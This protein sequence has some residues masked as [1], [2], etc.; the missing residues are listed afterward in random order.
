MTPSLEIGNGNW[1]VQ[2]DSLLGYKTINGKYYPREMSVTRA[3]TATRVNAAGL[4]ELVPYNLLQYSEDFSNVIWVKTQSTIS[5]NSTTSPS[6]LVNADTL[7][8]DGVTAQ[9]FVYQLL[10]VTSGVSY[11]MSTYA[12]KNTNN[13]VQIAGGSVL[14]GANAWANFDLNSGV[15]GSV[16]SAATATIT[17][18][19]NGWYRCTM[20][21]PAIATISGLSALYVLISSATSLRAETNSLSTSVFLWGAQLVEGTQ[22]LNYL[23]TTDRL[24]IAR[25]DYSLGQ[26]NLL[27]EPQRTNAIRNST[28][29]GAVVGSPGTLPTNWT[30]SLIGLTREI[31][32][33]GVENGLTYIDVRFSGVSTGNSSQRILF[34]NTTQISATPS[35]NWSLSAYIK[36]V[37][38]PLPPVSAQFL[39]FDLNSSG[40]FIGAGFQDISI[41]NTLNRFSYSRTTGTDPLIARLQPILGFTTLAGQSYDFTF[42]IAAPQ[43]EAGAFPT[44]FIPTISTSVTRNADVISRSNIFTNGYIT[45]AGGTW[46]VDFKGNVDLIRSGSAGGLFLNTGTISLAGDGFLFR[47]PTTSSQ[48]MSIIKYNSGTPSTLYNTLTENVKAAIKWNGTTADIFVN[49]VKVVSATAFTA[50]NMENL[51]GEGQNRTLQINSMSLYPTPLSDTELINLTT[52]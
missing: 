47:N 18:V 40:G 28:N 41:T 32:G 7:T 8:G 48:K 25:V 44:S 24:D 9:H 38:Q 17:N 23:P 33:I 52:L 26:A 27:L 11:T 4:V 43:I 13:F 19:G 21:A 6:G 36:M 35:Q 1:A 34:E 49:G 3:T 5:S 42:R 46:F 20:T 2:S 50:T 10:S 51:I 39:I 12:K 37:S 15:V 22:A 16:G 14:F 31:V 29:T 30:T 45:S